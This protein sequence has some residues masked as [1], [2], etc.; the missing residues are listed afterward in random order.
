MA[1]KRAAK[2][3]ADQFIKA[4]MTSSS[5]QEVV[6]KLGCSAIAVTKRLRSYRQRGITG[7]PEFD[8]REIR[9]ED[10]QALVDKYSKRR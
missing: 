1:K 3:P 4:V 5:V 8:A 6:E 9:L 10:V 7:L 2:I